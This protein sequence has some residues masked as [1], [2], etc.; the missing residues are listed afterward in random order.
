M[1]NI[2]LTS[3]FRAFFIGDRA[4]DEMKRKEV[5]LRSEENL[6]IIYHYFDFATLQWREKI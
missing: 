6:P 3:F 1:Q 4:A 5:S 2:F